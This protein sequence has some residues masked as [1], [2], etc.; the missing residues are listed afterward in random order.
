MS[1]FSRSSALS[2]GLRLLTLKKSELPQPFLFGGVVSDQLPLVAHLNLLRSLERLHHLRIGLRLQQAFFFE[3]VQQP[4]GKRLADEV[5]E[6]ASV[7]GVVGMFPCVVELQSMLVE[8]HDEFNLPSRGIALPRLGASQVR[9]A[10]EDDRPE[11]P[12]FLF[13]VPGIVVSVLS[14]V[15]KIVALL[16]HGTDGLRK[17]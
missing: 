9:V 15:P 1:L 11:A 3:P 17:E 7:D 13:V 4:V 16:L 12:A 6:L 10:D 5:G 8:P 2:L 14:P